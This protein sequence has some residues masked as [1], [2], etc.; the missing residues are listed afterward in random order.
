MGAQADPAGR[1]SGVLGATALLVGIV[2]A[3]ETYIAAKT[4]RA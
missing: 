2:E 1:A 4:F 3:V